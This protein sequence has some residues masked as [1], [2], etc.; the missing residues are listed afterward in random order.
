MYIVWYEQ[1][2]TD[3][4]TWIMIIYTVCKLTSKEYQQNFGGI[5]ISVYG[6]VSFACQQ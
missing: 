1:P 5:L 6:N 2:C 3:I 4:A